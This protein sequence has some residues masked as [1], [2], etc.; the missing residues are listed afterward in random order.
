MLFILQ[1][2]CGLL[3]FICSIL[4]LLSSIYSGI[5]GNWISKHSENCFPEDKE[6]EVLEACC[7][8]N[9]ISKNDSCQ[10]RET[11]LNSF[12]PIITTMSYEN[13]K[14]RDLFSAVKDYLI[15]QCALMGVGSGVCLW[16]LQMTIHRLINEYSINRQKLFSRH[17]AE[18]QNCIG[19]SP[20]IPIKIRCIQTNDKSQIFNELVQDKLVHNQITNEQSMKNCSP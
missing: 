3:S 6:R 19:Q 7:F 9:L 15:L 13:I 11:R 12:S 20:V 17:T 14:C 4:C 16:L 18:D 2:I 8:Q 5:H 1:I 10:C